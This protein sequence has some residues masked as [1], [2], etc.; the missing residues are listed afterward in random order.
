MHSFFFGES[1]MTITNNELFGDKK[2]NFLTVK[3]VAQRYRT[4]EAMIYRWISERRFP[5]NVVLKLGSKI[6]IN[7]NSLEFFESEGGNLFDK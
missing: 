1:I 6:L 5:E 2:I 7:R 4:S 3:E